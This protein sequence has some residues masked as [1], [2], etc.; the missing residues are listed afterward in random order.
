[1]YHE[2]NL[3]VVEEMNQ[4]ESCIDFILMVVQYALS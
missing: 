1:M 3:G 4:S 2:V